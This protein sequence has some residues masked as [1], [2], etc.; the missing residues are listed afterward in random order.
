MFSRLSIT[1]KII[2]IT[3]V[4]FVV[5]SICLIFIGRTLL[6]SEEIHKQAL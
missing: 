3:V 2:G 6:D 1:I 5:M 4:A